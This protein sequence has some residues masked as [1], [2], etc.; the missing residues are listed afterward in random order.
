MPVGGDAGTGRSSAIFVGDGAG[1]GFG[2]GTMAGL[3]VEPYWVTAE[4]ACTA[5]WAWRIAAP[6]TVRPAASVTAAA[7]GGRRGR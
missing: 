4:A 7:R 6:A 2:G 3:V 1:C 5:W